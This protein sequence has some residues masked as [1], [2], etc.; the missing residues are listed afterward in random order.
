MADVILG[1]VAIVSITVLIAVIRTNKSK[2]N[3]CH[4]NCENCGEQNVCGI[5]KKDNG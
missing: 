3:L 4:Y 1:T 5:K 2:C